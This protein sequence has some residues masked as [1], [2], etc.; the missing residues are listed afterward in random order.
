MLI[1]YLPVYLQGFDSMIEATKC[2]LPIDASSVSNILNKTFTFL[3][4]SYNMHTSCVC[5][6]LFILQKWL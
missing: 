1:F 2:G 5:M 3:I 4:L 6:F